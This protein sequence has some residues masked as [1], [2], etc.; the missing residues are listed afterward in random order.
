MSKAAKVSTGEVLILR[1][2]FEA[3]SNDSAK[4]KGIRARATCMVALLDE[5]LMWRE[6]AG[7]ET[8]DG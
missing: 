2:E 3:V 8:H 1:K 7:S 5:V 4:P 6:S